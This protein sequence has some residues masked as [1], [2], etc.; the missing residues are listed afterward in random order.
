MSLSEQQ[1]IE[2]LRPVT[3]PE[4]NVSI[5]ELGMVKGVTARRGRVSATIALTVAGCPMRDEVTR[6]VR[7]ALLEVRGV[8]GVDVELTVMTPQELEAVRARVQGRSADPQA[9][10][11]GQAGGGGHSHGH[12]HGGGRQPLGHEEGRPNPFG[13]Q[14]RTRVIGISSGKGGVG[15][16]SVTV[17]LAVSLA[18]AGHD[19]AI[20]DADVYGFSVPGMLGVRQDPIVDDLKMLPPAAH[21]VRC[22]SMGFFL[23]DEQPVV[24]RGPMLH[25]ALEQFLVDVAWGDPEFLLVDMPPG[26]GDVALS[27]AQ[28]L[29]TSEMYVVTTPQ[30]AARKVAQRSAYMA[31]KLN[32]PMRGVIENMSWWTMPD[33]SRQTP[34]GEGGGSQLAGELEVP[35]L[36]Q[37]PMDPALREGGDTGQPIVTSAP[38][39]E[40]GRAF[41]DLA[42]AIVKRGKARVFRSELT[43]R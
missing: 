40:V 41:S 42:G 5:V 27:M 34:F 11:Q 3:D 17:N 8:K 29:P 19:V 18:A 31:K 15:K 39:S 26:T 7:S 28:Y 9:W 24:W 25:K 23:E 16:S 10:Q 33:G 21:G 43:V 38:D 1:L 30:P 20:L 35:L 36:G 14:S 22:I 32:M 4:L 12:S 6:R 13:P 2:A 37:I